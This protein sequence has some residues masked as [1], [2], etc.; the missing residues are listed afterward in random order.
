MNTFEGFVGWG[1]V[2]PYSKWPVMQQADAAR[3]SIVLRE[4]P[5]VIELSEEL[6]FP[7][8]LGV[9]RE[10]DREGKFQSML[11]RA[12][13]D[14]WSISEE[15]ANLIALHLSDTLDNRSDRELWFADSADLRWDAISTLTSLGDRIPREWQV[16]WA[17]TPDFEDIWSAVP[18]DRREELEARI[19][20]DLLEADFGRANDIAEWTVG[21][22][23]QDWIGK[24]TISQGIIYMIANYLQDPKYE[25]PKYSSSEWGL[26]ESCAD[27]ERCVTSAWEFIQEISRYWLDKDDAEL[28]TAIE[29]YETLFWYYFLNIVSSVFDGTFTMEDLAPFQ[30]WKYGVRST[31]RSFRCKWCNQVLC[32]CWWKKPEKDKN[33]VKR[34]PWDITK[35]GVLSNII[36][37]LITYSN[38]N[39]WISAL[40]WFVRVIAELGEYMF[41]RELRA[42]RGHK[43]Y[44]NKYLTSIDEMNSRFLKDHMDDLYWEEWVITEYCKEQWIS[45]SELDPQKKHE[46]EMELI[47]ENFLK[48]VADVLM[49]FPLAIQSFWLDAERSIHRALQD[50]AQKVGWEVVFT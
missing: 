28:Q 18:E 26:K 6:L 34:M 35:D 40:F 48:E 7:E 10:I 50:R 8:L 9:I 23:K 3:S 21:G 1:W 12:Q 46:L 29:K 13:L 5:R 25:D 43:W 45:Q 15:L 30:H 44:K 36:W 16:L 49:W 11:R 32:V 24:R 42:C 14:D 20:L 2:S 22:I 41:V 19:N 17:L 33:G 27:K 37:M 4:S 38:K 39:G 31:D 47:E